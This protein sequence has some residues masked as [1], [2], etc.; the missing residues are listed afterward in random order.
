MLTEPKIPLAGAIVEVPFARFMA[1]M[2]AFSAETVL[3]RS[4]VR[5]DLASIVGT[6]GNRENTV[7]REGC[8]E[9]PEP[10]RDGRQV[11]HYKP[12]ANRAI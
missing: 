3:S 5:R 6:R 11:C 4:F 7:K 12:R 1:S 9:G 2:A 10:E 8:E